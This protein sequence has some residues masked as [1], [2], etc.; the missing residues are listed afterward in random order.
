[1]SCLQLDPVKEDTPMPPTLKIQDGKTLAVDPLMKQL[2]GRQPH[3]TFNL[4]IGSLKRRNKFP[5]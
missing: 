1:M 4:G 5:N 3:S 2:R